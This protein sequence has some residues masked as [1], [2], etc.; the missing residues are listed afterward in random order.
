MLAIGLMSGTSLDGVDVVLCELKGDFQALHVKQLDYLCVAYPEKLKQRVQAVIEDRTPSIQTISSVNFEL[1]HWYA[2]A[3]QVMLD[4]H[5]LKGSDLAF[6]AN[7]GQTLYH[8]PHAQDAFVASTLQLGES[9]LIAYR[10]RV[11]VIDNFR[12]MDL[13]AEGE[14]APLV[15][16]S[17]T[18]LYQTYKKPFAL[19]NIGGIS[20]VTIL[21]D[22]SVVAFDCG[23]GNM[24]I[25]AAMEHF[26]H[27]PYDDHGNIAA[28]GNVHQALLNQ[29]LAHPFI[30]QAPP[31]STG[32]EAFGSF[33]VEEL[34]RS[35]KHIPAQDIVTTFT[36]FTAKAIELAI[37]SL[38]NLPKTLII[39]GGGAHNQTLKTLIQKHLSELMVL[40]QDEIG[41]DSD[42]KEAMAFVIMGY[43]FL[44][45]VPANLP[46]VTGAKHA[47]ILGKCTPNPFKASN[48]HVELN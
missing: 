44:K 16:F 38:P 18:I 2:D 39:G 30:H 42:A 35:Y 41:F 24:M 11:D 19:V 10:H 26:Y 27:Q 17:E 6:V 5:Q 37:R 33:Y 9:S 32:R 34:L 7:H 3:V 31:K 48:H 36:V 25:N 28:S 29:L 22:E 4:R 43:A 13:A 46:S 45:N 47:V 14:G 40:T 8:Q 1:G 15:P 23:P 12:V 20:N 21:D